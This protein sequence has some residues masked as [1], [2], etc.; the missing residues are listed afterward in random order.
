MYDFRFRILY[1]CT[2]GEDA[3]FHLEASLC[4]SGTQLSILKLSE[5]LTGPGRSSPFGWQNL[6]QKS[7]RPHTVSRPGF[8]I[9]DLTDSPTE[10]TYLVKRVAI[11]VLK[12]GTGLSTTH[13][14]TE[15]DVSQHEVST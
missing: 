9:L 15:S 8:S 10:L 7:L 13:C 12:P 11:R 3:Y 1:K 2:I 6:L 4:N 14:S 5:F